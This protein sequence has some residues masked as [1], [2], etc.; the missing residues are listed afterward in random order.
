MNNQIRAGVDPPEGVSAQLHCGTQRNSIVL[1]SNWGWML[2]SLL[3]SDGSWLNGWFNTLRAAGNGC[4]RVYLCHVKLPWSWAS[5]VIDPSLIWQQIFS[6]IEALFRYIM[7]SVA[8]GVYSP[9]S[10]WFNTSH[11]AFLM[12]CE[13]LC[14]NSQQLVWSST[15]PDPHSLAEILPSES[16]SMSQS[17]GA[18]SAWELSYSTLSVGMPTCLIGL[19]TRE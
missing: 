10:H 9:I 13:L 1:Q 7:F 16:Q 6:P 4:A 11:S 18:C 2:V 3:T 15:P 19:N 8:S 17:V 12:H 14:W 5:L